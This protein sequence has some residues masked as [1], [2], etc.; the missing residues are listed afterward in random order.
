M[1]YNKFCV[2]R[3]GFK[4][5]QRANLRIWKLFQWNYYCIVFCYV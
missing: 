5:C 3:C 1:E 2:V 4:C